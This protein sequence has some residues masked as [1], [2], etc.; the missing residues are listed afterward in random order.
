MPSS[1]LFPTP[2]PANSP[3][4]WPR[5]T[6]RSALIARTPTSSVVA[7]GAR[8][9]GLKGRLC[10]G[11]NSCAPIG[12]SRSSGRPAP[13]T[14]RPSSSS[15]TGRYLPWSVARRRA[16]HGWPTRGRACTGSTWRTDAPGETPWMSETGIRNSRSPA[17]PTTSAS[18]GGPCRCSIRQMLPSGSLSPTDSMTKPATRVNLPRRGGAPAIVARCSHWRRNSPTRPGKSGGLEPVIGAPEIR[19][20]PAPARRNV[21]VEIALFGFDSAPARRDRRVVDKLTPSTQPFRVKQASDQCAIRRVDAQ[22]DALRRLRQLAQRRGHDRK[23]EFAAHGKRLADQLAREH[24]REIEHFVGEPLL[25]IAHA[26]GERR[27]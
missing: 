3:S 18:T 14:T 25:V 15:P 12:P 20:Q 10:S 8:S 4:R 21:H 26:F 23:D 19:Q 22:L 2:L 13:S 16:C 7:I 24:E 6:V 17:K 11:R 1:T 9:I 27:E 5:P